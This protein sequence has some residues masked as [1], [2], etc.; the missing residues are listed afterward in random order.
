LTFTVV[1][2]DF[3]LEHASKLAP[4]LFAHESASDE[5]DSVIANPPYLKLQKSD[6]RALAAR[7]IVHGQPN[8]YSLFMAISVSLLAPGGV[9]V[10]ITPRS[11]ATGAYFRRFRKHLLATVTPEVVHVFHSRKQ[12]F[13]DDAV[14]QENVIMRSR[15]TKTANQ[16]VTISSSVGVDDLLGGPS[17][18][19]PLRVVVNRESANL[20]MHFPLDETDD[21][22]LEFVRAWPVDFRRLGLQISTGPVVA[23]RARD[24]LV[25]KKNGQH[26]APLLW[27]QHIKPMS[28]EWPRPSL[29]KPQYFRVEGAPRNLLVPDGSYVL[30][31][32][33]SAKEELRRLVAAPLLRGELKCDHLALENHLNYIHRPSSE[34]LNEEAVGLAALLSSRLLDRYFRVSSGSTQVNASELRELPLP[35]QSVLLS[36]GAEMARVQGKTEKIEDIVAEVIGIPEAL[37][38]RLTWGG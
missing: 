14:L 34:L 13:R 37:R 3:V 2:K 6:P 17:R 26:V 36:L 16:R 27:L 1:P 9:M 35:P 33:F 4:D 29:R 22:V 18:T 12:A 32:R 5:Y 10:T 21:E 8:I 38:K 25:E 30:L 20:V 19:V 15:R 28:V 24:F 23:F 7:S 11:F 31:R